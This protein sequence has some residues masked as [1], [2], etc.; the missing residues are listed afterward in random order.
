MFRERWDSLKQRNRSFD[1]V[2]GS[3]FAGLQE[4]AGIA[5][6]VDRHS[7]RRTSRADALRIRAIVMRRIRAAP[8]RRPKAR[9]AVANPSQQKR[10]D[11][12]G[13]YERVP[14]VDQAHSP[15]VVARDLPRL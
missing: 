6:D 3:K 10:C 11:R 5:G 14:C 9:A 1:R 13:S 12:H 7:R 8:V 15:S 4:G 2:G